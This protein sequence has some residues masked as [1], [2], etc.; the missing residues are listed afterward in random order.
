[1]RFLLLIIT[2]ISLSLSGCWD[3]Q[4]LEDF[5]YIVSMGVDKSP[6]GQYDFTFR[7]TVPGRVETDG[8][9]GGQ[10]PGKVSKLITVTANTF[11]ESLSL[12]SVGVERQLSFDHCKVLLFSEELA[13]QDL[14]ALLDSFLR[15]NQLRLT[16]Q[17]WTV[18]NR[19]ARDV[20][21]VATPVLEQSISR[22]IESLNTKQ[23]EESRVHT[24][25]LKDLAVPL[26]MYHYDVIL[27]SFGINELVEEEHKKNKDMNELTPTKE[28]REHIEK[29]KGSSPFAGE[30]SRSGGNPI[31][32]SG[33]IVFRIGKMA[34]ELNSSE[35]R[36]YTI[37]TDKFNKGMFTFSYPEDE[38]NFFSVQLK[39]ARPR[40]INLEQHGEKLKI[41][42]KVSLEG[43]LKSLPA[44]YQIVTPEGFENLNRYIE[45]QLKGRLEDTIKK[46]Q[47]MKADP[48]FFIRPWRYQTLTVPEFK[49]I[50]WREMYS[51]A[52]IDV[53]VSVKLRRQGLLQ[54][55]IEGH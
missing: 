16:L 14:S 5:A 9:K 52:E 47:E 3:R 42:V 25:T 48:F 53:D 21:M 33:G 12:L 15:E 44:N 32:F 35:L 8:S 39:T 18:R 24:V 54:Q 6:N 37:L 19:P 31:S 36:S 38:K 40:K 50:P 43:S 46:C 29:K 20:F 27:P 28:Y 49:A 17:V 22:Y 26:E 30:T 13:R 1:M 41:Q 4:E 2:L 7:I 10:S 34:G 45:E 55:P 11:H 23:R 51:K